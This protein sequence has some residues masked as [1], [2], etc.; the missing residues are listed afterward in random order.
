VTTLGNDYHRILDELRRR[1]VVG[2]ESTNR[3]RDG[4]W[5]K[6]QM[7]ARASGVT[8]RSRDGYYAPAE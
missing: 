2:Y 8:I 5:R 6:V 7:R 1:Y 3:T 4:G